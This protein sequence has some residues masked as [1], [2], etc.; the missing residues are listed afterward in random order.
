MVWRIH[1]TSFELINSD[2]LEQIMFLLCNKRRV[3]SN[4]CDFKHILFINIKF[5]RYHSTLYVPPPFI[6]RCGKG[7][8]MLAYNISYR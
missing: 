2:L 3:K 8:S 1:F 6:L 4:P 7:K 5:R